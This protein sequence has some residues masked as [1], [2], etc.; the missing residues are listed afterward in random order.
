MMS[1]ITR[2]RALSNMPVGTTTVVRR[3]VRPPPLPQRQRPRRRR[4]RP[5]PRERPRQQAQVRQPRPRPVR[6]AVHQPFPPLLRRLLHRQG[7]QPTL[8]PVRQRLPA[9]QRRPERLAPSAVRWVILSNQIRFHPHHSLCRERLSAICLAP[10]CP[11][12]DF[13]TIVEIG[14]ARSK[15]SILKF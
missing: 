1:L 10:A 11:C 6:Q 8:K 13:S 2:V 5:T 3:P 7:R 9:L 14:A 12:S 4:E 15:V